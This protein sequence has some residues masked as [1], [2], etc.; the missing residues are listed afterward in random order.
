MM[1]NASTVVS[2][3]S[4]LPE[5]SAA[6]CRSPR[7]MPVLTMAASVLVTILI[8]VSTL[9]GI[10]Q[11]AHA[12]SWPTGGTAPSA[13]QPA[14]FESAL[15][16]A[17]AV[18]TQVSPEPAD[19]VEAYFRAVNDGEY[20]AAW[21]LGGKNILG[22]TYDYFVRSFVDTARDEVTINSVLGDQVEVELDATQTDGSHRFFAGNYTVQNGVI[23]KADI[24]QV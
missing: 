13:T 18:P 6:R 7:S 16:S 4:A 17:A 2:F 20:I 15:Q 14:S 21:A 5:K 24:H 9:L 11:S 3:F 1:N 19:V 10:T 8:G 12:D 22:G 23:V